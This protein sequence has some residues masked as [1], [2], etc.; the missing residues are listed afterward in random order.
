MGKSA[1]ADFGLG[2]VLEEEPWKSYEP[3]ACSVV[4]EVA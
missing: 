1:E 2:A 3:A 4:G